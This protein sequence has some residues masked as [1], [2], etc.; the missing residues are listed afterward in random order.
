MIDVMS[1]S[2]ASSLDPSGS[3]PGIGD[4]VSGGIEPSG[5]SRNRLIAIAAAVT[6]AAASLLILEIWWTAPERD[7]M[8]AFQR[9]LNAANTA[10]LK[11]AQELCT[12]RYLSK[13]PLR[14]AP[15][16]GI[17]GIPRMISKNFRTWRRGSDR[18]WVCT[19][20]RMG[21][22][23]QFAREGKKWRF[24]GAVGMLMKNG[25]IGGSVDLES[26]EPAPEP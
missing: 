9:L 21:P 14:L 2:F 11:T 7:S 10:D 1:F 5:S 24:D 13:H 26:E 23:F 22:V 15:R 4:G 25:E 16:G 8:I 18:I 17:V 3:V 12:S 19:G 20:D 6:I